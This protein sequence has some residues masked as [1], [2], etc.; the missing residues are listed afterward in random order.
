MEYL[1]F[2]FP[3]PYRRLVHCRHTGDNLFFSMGSSA[4][5]LGRLESVSLCEDAY[6]VVIGFNKLFRAWHR[7]R[8]RGEFIKLV[9][10]AY[11]IYRMVVDFWRVSTPLAV[12]NLR[13]HL[14]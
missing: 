13:W 10:S 7:K 11:A 5:N 2:S 9:R 6:M 14:K 3:G 8:F 1:I 4:S 12:A